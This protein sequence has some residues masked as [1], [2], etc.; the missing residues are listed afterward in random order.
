[1]NLTSEASPRLY[2]ESQTIQIS[3]SQGAIYN[4]TAKPNLRL[5][6]TG[7]LSNQAIRSQ[8]KYGRCQVDLCWND[9]IGVDAQTEREREREWYSDIP[10]STRSVCLSVHFTKKKGQVGCAIR[11]V[12]Y[13]FLDMDLRKFRIS[14]TGKL[15]GSVSASGDRLLKYPILSREPKF[16]RKLELTKDRPIYN[17]LQRH[18]SSQ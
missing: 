12:R 18:R 17:L 10:T 15:P 11:Y 2:A 6:V 14:C 5:K 7:S 3:H 9:P 13:T 8:W 16:F 4:G 1:M